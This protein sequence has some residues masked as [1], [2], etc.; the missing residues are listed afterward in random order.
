MFVLVLALV[1]MPLVGYLY[2]RFRYTDAR[3]LPELRLTEQPA[4]EPGCAALV[5]FSY[6]NQATEYCT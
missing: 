5:S 1:F 2:A 4:T 6:F 3:E